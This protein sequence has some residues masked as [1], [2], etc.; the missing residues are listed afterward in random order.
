MRLFAT[1]VVFPVTGLV[2]ALFW[3][4]LSSQRGILAFNVSLREGNQGRY[5]ALIKAGEGNPLDQLANDLQAVWVDFGLYFMVVLAIGLV[6]TVIGCWI[7]LSCANRAIASLAKRY[8]SPEGRELLR[9][10]LGESRDSVIEGVLLV[11]WLLALVLWWYVI[12]ILAGGWSYY[13]KPDDADFLIGSL[14]KLS[15]AVLVLVGIGGLAGLV[16]LS[17]LRERRQLIANQDRLSDS[18]LRTLWILKLGYMTAAS[19]IL[20]PLASSLF[21]EGVTSEAS[22]LLRSRAEPA[23]H[24]DVTTF[25]S[26]LG[27]EDTALE[28]DWLGPFASVDLVL[29]QHRSEVSDAL[30][31]AMT[32]IGLLEML[33]AVGL[34]TAFLTSGLRRGEW[35]L[36]ILIVGLGSTLLPFVIAAVLTLRTSVPDGVVFTLAAV[37]GAA[38]TVHLF[39]RGGAE[40]LGNALAEMLGWRAPPLGKRRLLSPNKRLQGQYALLGILGILTMVAIGWVAFVVAAAGGLTYLAFRR[41]WLETETGAELGTLMVMGLGTLFVT[42]LGAAFSISLVG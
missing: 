11:V 39:R 28:A 33:L 34:T 8:L 26:A 27:P 21:F 35:E 29:D 17:S 22:Q 23:V 31:G 24:E 10:Q 3:L 37:V 32:S 1:H 5:P 12:G 36:P 4:F 38:M 41:R 40:R 2:L 13:V 6:I 25:N 9:K 7:A 18:D 42:W 19:V 15:S 20:V 14:R 16:I 30:L